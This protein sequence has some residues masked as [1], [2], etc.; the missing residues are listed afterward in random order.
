LVGWRCQERNSF[1]KVHVHYG[2]IAS[3]DSVM[4]DAEMRNR[5][6]RDQELNILCFEME[7]AGLMNSLPCLVIRGICDY[8][9]SH[10]N[11]DWHNYAALAAAA[12][13]RELLIVL[14]EQNVVGMP[15]WVAEM[16]RRT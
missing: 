6:A 5:Y 7:A 9:D 1:R 3:G 12:Y 15:S 16:G 10:K 11:D 14:N 8:S 4:K 13:A 2:T